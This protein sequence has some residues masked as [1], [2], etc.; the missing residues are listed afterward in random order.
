MRIY[1]TMNHTFVGVLWWMK[2]LWSVNGL[3]CLLVW[4][5]HLSSLLTFTGYFWKGSTARGPSVLREMC[6]SCVFPP[7]PLSDMVLF[8][9]QSIGGRA[10][11]EKSLTSLVASHRVHQ[12][13]TNAKAINLC[14]KRLA[15]ECIPILMRVWRV[16][17]L[18]GSI[19][20]EQDLLVTN[21]FREIL[22]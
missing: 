13:S 22:P 9:F 3:C 4:K 15:A 1:R 5:W 20:V 7:P 11:V 2:C 6:A 16:G 21:G 12:A 17:D 18:V 19:S 14:Y 10:R 8:A